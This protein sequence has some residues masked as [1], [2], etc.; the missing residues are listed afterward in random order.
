M[1]PRI[2]SCLAIFPTPII[3]DFFR[4]RWQTKLIR[5]FIVIDFCTNIDQ[6]DFLIAGELRPLIAGTFTLENVA[7]GH[8]LLENREAIGKVIVLPNG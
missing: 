7:E 6:D 2:R 3:G 4:V 5:F 1:T 8:N